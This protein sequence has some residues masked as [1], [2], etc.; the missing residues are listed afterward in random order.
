MENN[1]YYLPDMAWPEIKEALR[2]IQ[3]AIIPVGATEQHGPYLSLSCDSVRAE[4]FSKL[5]GK[6]LYPKVV[7]APTISVAISPHHLAFPGTITLR[8]S[9]LIAVLKDYVSS[10]Y[11]HGLRKFFILNS[12]GGNESTIKTAVTEI[13]GEYRDIKIAS[14][15]YTKLAPKAIKKNIKSE[16][17]GHSCEREV[18]EILYLAPHILRKDKL[19]KGEF[20][21]MPYPF[22]SIGGDPVNVPYTLEELTSNGALGDA[23]KAAR[24]IGEEI[25]LEA[26]DNL[27]IFFRKFME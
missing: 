24:E 19:V 14:A 21:G 1:L 4:A 16:V 18:S 6:R 2:Y 12:H 5:L 13:T 22:M 8:P 27:E 23:T 25:C 7:I 20:K 9:T 15:Q 26:L 17:F 3:L 11:H 10:L